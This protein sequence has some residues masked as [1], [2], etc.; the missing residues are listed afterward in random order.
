LFNFLS[1]FHSFHLFVGIAEVS[2]TS[3]SAAGHSYAE[4]HVWRARVPESPSG[5]G[6]WPMDTDFTVNTLLY[7]G[8][9][10]V[11]SLSNYLHGIKWWLLEPHSGYIL[12]NPS[13]HCA[14]T[15]EKLLA[16][17]L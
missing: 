14:A 16:F 5:V 12:E 15:P 6:A 1:F 8:A 7:P 11:S 2:Y 13:R 3:N 17:F 10:S 4:G 9:E